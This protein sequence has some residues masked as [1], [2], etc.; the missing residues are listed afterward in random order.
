MVHHAFMLPLLVSQG[1]STSSQS[2]PQVLAEI[3][4][5]AA[6]AFEGISLQVGQ[7]CMAMP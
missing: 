3:V 7:H 4:A 2:T 5:V 6:S 1:G